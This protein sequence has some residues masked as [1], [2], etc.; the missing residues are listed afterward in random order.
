M[1]PLTP[2]TLRAHLYALTHA[3]ALLTHGPVTFSRETLESH[4]PL[5]QAQHPSLP[6]TYTAPSYTLTGDDT[7]TA[8][9]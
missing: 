6:A 3:S 8:N 5:G 9:P 7:L 2:G 4:F 1:R